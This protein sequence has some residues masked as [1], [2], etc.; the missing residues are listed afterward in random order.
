MSWDHKQDGIVG[1]V[2]DLRKIREA[3]AQS[4]KYFQ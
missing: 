1:E 4:R 2:I 3:N